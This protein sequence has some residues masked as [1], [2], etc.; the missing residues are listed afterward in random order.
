MAKSNMRS[1]AIRKHYR[2]IEHQARI[3]A[4]ARYERLYKQKEHVVKSE[5]PMTS[6]ALKVIASV[7]KFFGSIFMVKTKS[8]NKLDLRHDMTMGADQH[9]SAGPNRLRAWWPA[10]G[11]MI[12]TRDGMPV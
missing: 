10:L 12:S 3:D 9:R 7:K 8:I 11:K 1:A 2:R 6:V 4:R 5:V